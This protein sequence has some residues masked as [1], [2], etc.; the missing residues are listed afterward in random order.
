MNTILNLMNQNAQT[1]PQKNPNIKNKVSAIQ[2][3]MKTHSYIQ[4]TTL[5]DA[6]IEV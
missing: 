2:S 1:K 3:S 5:P 4:T 6:K